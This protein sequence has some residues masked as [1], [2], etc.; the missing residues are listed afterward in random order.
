MGLCGLV[1]GEEALTGR[2][3]LARKVLVLGDG[4]CGKTSLLFV[5]IKHEFPQT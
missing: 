5:L 1:G 2:R 3:T 4:A